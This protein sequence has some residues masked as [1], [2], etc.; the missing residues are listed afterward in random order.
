ML[1]TILLHT[2][3]NACSFAS[4]GVIL[5]VTRDGIKLWEPSA[6]AVSTFV[7]FWKTGSFA[8]APIC[9]CFPKK[10][11]RRIYK[12]KSLQ[13]TLNLR[14]ITLFP[15]LDMKVWNRSF[16]PLN[17]S[18]RV[19]KCKKPRNLQYTSF[20]IHF[21]GHA[22]LIMLDLLTTTTNSRFPQLSFLSNNLLQHTTTL[23]LSQFFNFVDACI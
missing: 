17:A 1:S 6:E 22:K 3:L 23:L 21:F 4:A 19:I 15:I 7:S 20:D 13:V 2:L 12:H 18:M 10:S 8:I 9:C 11:P 14:L 5:W 16:S